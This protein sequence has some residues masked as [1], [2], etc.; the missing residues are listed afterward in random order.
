[1]SIATLVYQRL[2]YI[3]IIE[4]DYA[5]VDL[6]LLTCHGSFVMSLKETL[7]SRVKPG[8]SGLEILSDGIEHAIVSI[9]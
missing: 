3:E 9:R 8:L 6:F 4:M 1:M 2:L 5:V 7:G